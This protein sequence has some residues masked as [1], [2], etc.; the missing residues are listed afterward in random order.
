MLTA[1]ADF[2]LLADAA[3]LR[4]TNLY[5]LP[6]SMLVQRLEWIFFE[7]VILGIVGDEFPGIVAAEPE[8]CLG[9]V[10]RAE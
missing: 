4:Y 5:Q 6:D 10:I 7:D 8:G 2:K 9:Q 1:N 3:P